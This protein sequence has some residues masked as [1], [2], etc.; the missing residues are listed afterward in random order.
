MKLTVIGGAGVRTPLLMSALARRQEAIGL[1]SVVLMDLD[2]SKLELFGPLSRYVAESVGGTFTLSW[3]SDAREAL[4][5]AGAVITTIRGGSE[6]GRVVD[7]SIALQ[8][9]VLGQETTG[10]GGFAMALRSIPAVS[11]Y[12]AMMRDI[13]P[14]AW[15]MNFTN[16]AGLV[17]QG[18][19]EA[20]PDLKIV[21]ICDTPIGLHREVAAAFG[22]PAEE[23]PIRFAGLN[24]LSWLLSAE[25][26]GENVVPRIV[27]DPSLIARIHQLG[28]FEPELIRLIGSL[29]NEYLYFYYYREQALGHIQAAGETRGRQVQ[30]LSA[31]LLRDLAEIVPAEHP[32]RAWTRYRQYLNSRHGTYMSTETG[33]ATHFAAPEEAEEERTPTAEEGEGYAG[34]A[35][36]ILTA[37]QGH[38]SRMVANVPNR[39]AIPGMRD[40][41]VVEIACRC[42][43][44]GLHPLPSGPLPE[45]ALLLMQQVKRYE[46]LT[47]EAI[48]THSRELAVEALMAHPLVGSYS[49]A[50]GLVTDYL[51]AHRDA[52]GEW[53]AA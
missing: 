38:E 10:P 1:D 20:F 36:D 13:C 47:V 2:E 25:V 39:G 52:V 49:L 8:H 40:D 53:P 6:H 22:R 43:S 31:E 37:A 50:R 41:D 45:D 26:D 16:P 12:A 29:P 46:R 24:H 30:R 23:V 34:V 48:R 17:A 28:L 35:L 7:E 4:T 11:V 15:L 3:T 14:D 5:G 32:Q 9:G 42:D 44:S 27:A 33:G 19:T 18:L 21:G 51:E